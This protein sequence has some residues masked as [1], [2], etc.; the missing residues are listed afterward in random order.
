MLAFADHIHAPKLDNTLKERETLKKHNRAPLKIKEVL[1]QSHT[2]S[3]NSGQ[4]VTIS[5]WTAEAVM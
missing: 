4:L 2:L 3:K 5:Y 1:L